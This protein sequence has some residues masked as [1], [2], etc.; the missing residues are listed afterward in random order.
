LHKSKV[1]STEYY[2]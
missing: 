1:L 2:S